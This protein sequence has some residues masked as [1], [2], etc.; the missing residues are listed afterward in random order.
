MVFRITVAR[1]SGRR[2]RLGKTR[3]GA[4]GGVTLRE[5]VEGMEGGREGGE[6]GEDGAGHAKLFP[7]RPFACRYSRMCDV[8]IHCQVEWNRN[9]L[10]Y[11]RS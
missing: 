9:F 5:E 6:G 7:F 3:K 2:E 1:F 10:C 11:K 4:D 8:Q